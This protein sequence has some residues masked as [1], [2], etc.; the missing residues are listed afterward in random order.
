MMT[1]SIMVTV[2]SQ[3]SGWVPSV[4]RLKRPKMVRVSWMFW[5]L[6]VYY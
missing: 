5:R 3:S 1:Q 4:T 2:R 6:F